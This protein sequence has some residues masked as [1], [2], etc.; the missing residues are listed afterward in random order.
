[1]VAVQAAAKTSL[2]AVP[3]GHYVLPGYTSV[4]PTG[5]TVRI[6]WRRRWDL[7]IFNDYWISPSPAKRA[8]PSDQY[9][10]NTFLVG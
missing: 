1:M 4:L 6:A 2:A 10:Y 3:G 7:S 5:V 8:A 9:T